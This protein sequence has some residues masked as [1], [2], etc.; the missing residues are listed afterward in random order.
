MST[1]I[2]RR[3]E[4]RNLKFCTDGSAR[5][6]IPSGLRARAQVPYLGLCA[7]LASRVAVQVP[8]GCGGEHDARVTSVSSAETP[9][10]AYRSWLP[11]LTA[12]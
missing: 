8:R 6:R 1:G 10:T 2:D 11:R 3:Q 7:V 5:V 4:T 12:G 9:E